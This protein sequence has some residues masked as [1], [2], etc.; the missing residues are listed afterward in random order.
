MTGTDTTGAQAQPKVHH[1][2]KKCYFVASRDQAYLTSPPLTRSPREWALVAASQR[3]RIPK[4]GATPIADQQRTDRQQQPSE[5]AATLTNGRATGWV[6]VLVCGPRRPGTR[7]LPPPSLK[8][9]SEEARTTTVI[10]HLTSRP[11]L[12]INIPAT[13]NHVSFPLPHAPPS[14]PPPPPAPQTLQ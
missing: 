5:L 9:S 11:R 13:I 4:R 3:T 1:N 2:N 8:R 14:P 12:I 6:N 10:R 7:P